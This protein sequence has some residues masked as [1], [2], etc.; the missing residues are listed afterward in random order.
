MTDRTGVLSCADLPG[1]LQ[2]Q[3]V[4]AEGKD[5][6]CASTALLQDTNAGDGCVA[7]SKFAVATGNDKM[8]AGEDSRHKETPQG[9]TR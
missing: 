3:M 5:L 4:C 9:N 8:K 1:L 7:G 2:C 6:A